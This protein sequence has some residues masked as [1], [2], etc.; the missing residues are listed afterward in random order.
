MSIQTINANTSNTVKSFEEM[1]E[2]PVNTKL[3]KAQT[4]FTEWKETS[5]QERADLLFGGTKHSGF[6]RELSE[7]GIQEFVNKKLIRVSDL[8]DPF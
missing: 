3:A 1:T 2:K 4:A 5:Y 7:L 6:C 8:N